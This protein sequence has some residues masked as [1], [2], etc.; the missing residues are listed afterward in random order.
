VAN[1]S[2]GI[3]TEIV[4]EKAGPRSA[5]AIKTFLKKDTFEE[6]QTSL[7]LC[8]LDI[9]PK[10][11]EHMKNYGIYPTRLLIWQGGDFRKTVSMLPIE[12][13]VKDSSLMIEKIKSEFALYKDDLTFPCRTLGATVQS[14][15]SIKSCK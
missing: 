7:V 12:D 6:I 2:V 14:F 8:A 3:C 1:L 11:Q 9:I 13:F 4:E 10:M 15:K 5:G